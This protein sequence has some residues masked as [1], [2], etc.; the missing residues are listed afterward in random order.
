MITGDWETGE[1]EV[2]LDVRFHMKSF[3]RSVSQHGG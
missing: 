1:G 2:L 3:Q